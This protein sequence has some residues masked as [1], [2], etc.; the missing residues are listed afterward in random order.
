[1]AARKP[2]PTSGTV[3]HGLHAHL[4]G[5]QVQQVLDRELDV[6]RLGRHRAGEKLHATADAVAPLQLL[7]LAVLHELVP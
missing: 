1:M 5:H 6:G 4:L 7:E 3:Q 2:P